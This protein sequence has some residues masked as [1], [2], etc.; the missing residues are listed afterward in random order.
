MSRF[1]RANTGAPYAVIMHPF[2]SP[3]GV[4]CQAPA[5]GYVAAID[6]FTNKVVWKHKNGTTRDIRHPGGVSQVDGALIGGL[7][8]QS[9][10]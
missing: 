2:M 1:G 4:P 9:S 6:L 10:F 3:L 8:I 5:W 7:K